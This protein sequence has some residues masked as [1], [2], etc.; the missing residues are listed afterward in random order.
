MRDAVAAQLAERK[1]D[2]KSR[3]TEDLRERQKDACDALRET[4]DVQ[5]QDLLQRQRD[6]RAAFNAGQ[7]LDN[8]RLGQDANRTTEPAAIGRNDAPANENRPADEARVNEG[9]TVS[10]SPFAVIP[11]ELVPTPRPTAEYDKAIPSVAPSSERAELPAPEPAN[12]VMPTVEAPEV[13]RQVADLAAG[14]IG[15]VAS[16]LADQLGEMFAPTPPEVREAQAKAAAKA[17]AEKPAP[18]EHDNPYARQIDAAMKIVE[19]ER[20][21]REQNRAYWE[22][23]DK[24]KDF[25]RDR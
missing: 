8:I 1:A 2:L 9:Q 6:E 21:Q 23:R 11:A 13:T 3:Q 15:Q 19:A 18:V 16:Y 25:E 7:T 5:Y 22:E 10:S 12:V 4:R 20:E 24:G 17:E 14:G